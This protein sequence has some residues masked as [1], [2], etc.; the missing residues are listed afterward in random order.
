MPYPLY[1]SRADGPCVWDVDGNRYIDLG[2]GNGA[3]MLGHNNSFVR[4]AVTSA[5]A[6]GIT[7]GLETETSI[8]AAELFLRLVPAAERVRF[9]NTGTEAMLHVLHMAR[10]R[11]G[12]QA[13]AKVEGAYHGWFDS[14]YVSTW[15]T[16]ADAGTDDQPLALP[17]TTGLLKNAT[18]DAIILP[19]NNSRAAERLLRPKAKDLA[20]IVVEPTLIDVGF[21]PAEREY[22]LTLRRLADE[23]G[24]VL[25]FDELLTGFRLARGGAQECYGMQAD[26]AIFGK[27]LGNGF[28][29]AAVAGKQE[30]MDVSAPGPGKAA[31]VGTFNGHAVTLAAVEASLTQLS[32]GRVTTHLQEQTEIL[33][34]EFRV[35]SQKYGINAQMQGGGGHIHWYFASEPVRN[36]RDA[37]RSNR[38]RYSAFISVLADE[39]FL[40]SNNY[41]LHHAFSYAHGSSEMTHLISA[42]DKGLAAAAQVTG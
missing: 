24:A 32:D 20:A 6:G 13:I 19:Y 21:I 26:L 42:M 5:L 28:P 18:T 35:L 9:V 27:A 23:T 40:V 31:F 16:L 2:M 41:L 30:Y 38:T 1:F 7:A 36:Y 29:V 15:P 4:E 10:T 12:R 25:V 37:A 22:L 34:K 17:G 14:V 3:I 11:T 8:R 33:V 39:G